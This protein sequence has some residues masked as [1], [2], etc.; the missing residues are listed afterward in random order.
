MVKIRTE[1]GI[2]IVT[3]DGAEIVLGTGKYGLREAMEFVSTQ[4]FM[5]VVRGEKI[6]T[7]LPGYS[8]TSLIPEIYP[9]KQVKFTESEEE[10]ISDRY[11]YATA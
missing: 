1:K 4:L 10:H 8:V 5:S 3:V 9:E 7:V 6:Y 2:T 11:V